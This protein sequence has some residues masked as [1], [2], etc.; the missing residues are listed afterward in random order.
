MCN[1]K[2]ELFGWFILNKILIR[3]ILIIIL[4]FYYIF[5]GFFLNLLCNLLWMSLHSCNWCLNKRCLK[6][7]FKLIKFISFDV[8]F[9]SYWVI[10]NINCTLLILIVY[11]FSILYFKYILSI[12]AYCLLIFNIEYCMLIYYYFLHFLCF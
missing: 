3:W 10:N 9:V 5:L 4:E 6:L 7:V 2:L 12:F 11:T 8:N 1:L